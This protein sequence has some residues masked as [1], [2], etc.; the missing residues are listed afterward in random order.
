MRPVRFALVVLLFLGAASGG[1][2]ASCNAVPERPAFFGTRGSID[3]PFL[4]PDADETVKLRPGAES[5]PAALRASAPTDVLITLVFKPPTGAPRNVFIAG[6]G[7]CESLEEPVCFFERL[8]CHVPR[9]CFTGSQVD[10]KVST[11]NEI[12][13]H[14]PATTAA[15]PVTIAVG[16]PDQPPVGLGK[17][18]C[19]QFLA[20]DAGA[21]LALC[22][23]HFRPPMGDDPPLAP[24]DPPP[25]ALVALPSSYDYSTVCTQSVGGKPKCSGT[26]HDVTYTVNPDGDVLMPINWRNIL[27]LKGGGPDLD[28]RQLQASTAVEAVLGQGQ[29]I[30][31]SS[32]VFLETTTQQGGGFSPNPVFMPT[33]RPDRPNEQTFFGT[34]DQGKSVLKFQRRRL[35]DRTCQP[36]DQPEAC[37]SA[38][39]CASGNCGLSA[40]AYFACDAGARFRLPCTQTAQCPQGA[41]RRVSD[42]G[43]VCVLVDGTSTTTSCHQ[44]ADCGATCQPGSAGGTCVAA[45]G[46]PTGP[47]CKQDSDC[48]KCGPGLF[49]FRNR[50]VKGLGTIKRIATGVPGV[51]E[52]GLSEGNPC[53]GSSACNSSVFGGVNCVTYRA[54]ALIYSTP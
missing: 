7:D 22:I 11:E 41:C 44:D 38:A 16:P 47:A 51:C 32:P 29:R 9:N 49:E 3:R 26:A 4:S 34:A 46:A 8:F 25:T 42:I 45:N 54:E 40:A 20:T 6:N 28:Q 12:S 14:F 19:E 48:G 53:T 1:V 31:V 37:E 2:H 43:S 35:W 15:G 24:N 52:S 17:L 5:K 50:T 23:D 13:F 18:P 39:D 21:N 30:R 36:P 27:R 10:L 33:E